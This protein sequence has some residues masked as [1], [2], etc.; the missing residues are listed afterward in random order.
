ML[1][2]RAKR[3]ISNTDSVFILLVSLLS[4]SNFVPQVGASLASPQIWP[5]VG[6]RIISLN[7]TC[8][9]TSGLCSYLSQG[10]LL[11]LGKSPGAHSWLGEKS[12]IEGA[13]TSARPGAGC[14]LHT[15][16]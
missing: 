8:D 5:R 14:D 2:P 11:P 7:H 6:A 16:G 4:F 3:N 12:V 10:F 1:K 13:Q 15:A 9:H